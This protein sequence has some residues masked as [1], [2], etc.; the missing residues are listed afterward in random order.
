MSTHAGDKA[1][2]LRLPNETDASGRDFGDAE[3]ALLREVLDSG[4]LNCT[5]GTL[6]DRLEKRWAQQLGARHCVAVTSGT[7]AIHAAVAAV[8]PEPGDEIVT[9]PVT[10]MG[11]ITPILYQSAIPIFADLDPHSLNISAQNIERV[12]TP[13]TRAI[14]VTHLFGAPCDMAPICELAQR[15]NLLLIEDAAQAPFATYR[16]RRLGT[17]GDIGCFSLQ[18]NKHVTSGEGG[19]V[20]TDDDALARRMKLFHDKAWGYGDAVPDLYFL[21]L[22]YRMTELQAAVALPQLDR[23]ESGVARRQHNAARL[24]EML[25]DIPALQVQAIPEQSESAWWKFALW[26]DAEIQG[27]ADAVGAYLREHFGL[28]S[29]PRYIQKPAFECEVLRER[30]TF[31]NSR[32]PF[33]GAHRDGLPPVEYRR[34]D[35]PGTYEGLSRVLVLPWNE[36]YNDAHLDYIA[37]ALHEAVASLNGSNR[38]ARA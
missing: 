37:R 35:F 33:E 18:Q 2:F 12:L 21:A 22:N 19:L 5:R 14:I 7:A 23:V 20:T 16:N 10:D 6:V 8:D 38:E 34:E 29:A 24:R 30:R 13:R 31:G 28:M 25:A 3:L 26:V 36:H 32:F 11:A 27:G 15:H 17:W 1:G 9:T 4:T